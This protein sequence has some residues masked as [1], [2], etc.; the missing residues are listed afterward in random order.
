[1]LTKSTFLLVLGVAMAMANMNNWE[2]LQLLNVDF[3]YENGQ[4][5][6]AEAGAIG[7]FQWLGYPCKREEEPN[8]N[9][10]PIDGQCWVLVSQP[11]PSQATHSPMG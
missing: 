4:L 2:N 8:Q 1:M 7:Q 9:G 11:R 5:Q 10:V 6:F 3:N